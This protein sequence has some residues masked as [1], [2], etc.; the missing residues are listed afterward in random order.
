VGVVKLMESLFRYL[1]Q[2]RQV[3][4]QPVPQ[5][6][7]FVFTLS[8][9]AQVA[10]CQPTPAADPKPKTTLETT[11]SDAGRDRETELRTRAR[12]S[13]QRS[14]TKESAEELP[15][16]YL[17]QRN[18]KKK[19]SPETLDAKSPRADRGPQLDYE[20]ENDREG[21]DSRDH[22]ISPQEYEDF[23][24][25]KQSLEYRQPGD[26]GYQYP[27]D[28]R[29]PENI[30]LQHEPI[31]DKDRDN[32]VYPN[33]PYSSTTSTNNKWIDRRHHEPLD[34]AKDLRD[35]RRNA[36]LKRFGESFFKEARYQLVDANETN[37]PHDYLL[38][39]GDQINVLTYNTKG[40]ESSM[41]LTI[42]HQG[43][44]Y[45]PGA[46]R[47]ELQGL[48]ITAAQS[49]LSSALS[50]K[51][52][53]L[54]VRISMNK[55]RKIRV[56]LIGEVQ[57]PG[58]YLV[59]PGSNVLDAL[60]AGGGPTTAGSYRKIQLQRGGSSIASV[61]LYGFLATGNAPS[62]RLVYG[63]KIFVP[64]A[65]PQVAMDGEVLRPAFYELKGEST[66]A[67][68]LKLAGGVKP[69]AYAG[70][71]HIERIASGT[72]RTMDDVRLKDAAAV[73][74]QGGDSVFVNPVLEDLSLSVF[75]EGAVR[76]PGWY[77]L[78][79]N[80]TVSSLIRKAQGL[81]DD[82]Y[83]GQ[84]EVF[85][86][87]AP[88]QPTELLGVDL[89]KALGGDRK[90]DI[91]LK[92][93][94]RVIVY[95]R[96]VATFNKERVRIDGE[97]TR[98]GEYP[99][100]EAM[101]VRD[102]L[103]QAGGVTPEASPKA[104]IARPSGDG[105]LALM[106]IEVAQVLDSP[107]AKSNYKLQNGDLLVIRREL[108]AN[109]WP[110]SITLGGEV[111]NPGIYPVDLIN[112]TL[113]SVIQRAGGLTDRAYTRGTVFVRSKAE[114]IDANNEAV[115]TE[116]FTTAQQVASQIAAAEAARQGQTSSA[117]SQINL[118]SL[119][120]STRTI[121]PRDI[122]KILSNQ[123]IPLRLEKL[124]KEHVG[125]PGVKDGDLVFI[126]TMPTT[127]VVSGAVLSPTSL[128]YD[129]AWSLSDYIERAGGLAKDADP[130]EI[131]IMRASGEVVKAE[132]V[133]RLIPG[134]VVLVPPKAIIAEPG[135]FER[136]VSILQVVSNAFVFSRILR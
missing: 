108:R 82:A 20:T 52:R 47:V 42:D 75:I 103:I 86:Q 45:L 49:K 35:T 130:E 101:T 73:R 116:V 36:D 67:S 117:G 23:L 27:L 118:S 3:L 84:A 56:F 126:P 134:D 26:K 39:E 62:P 123:R 68:L 106:P 135:A 102:L 111:M 124:L 41:P 91:P 92:G 13:A 104:E 89:Q 113:E 90:Q 80:M 83:P 44:V 51:F 105:R 132:K 32:Y 2:R 9:H 107:D 112:D 98:P 25:W 133:A 87:P 8:L 125:D 15:L 74:I 109:R 119:T 57:K 31:F 11:D 66:L 12:N 30:K 100:Y 81:Q 95:D 71:I 58:A 40:G 34:R 54:R 127:L 77:A 70:L 59:N 65:G 131:L 55:V 14:R 94:D 72:Y 4:S 43:E 110:A 19:P 99:R 50:A 114:L 5:A 6:V 48:P 63:D 1:S 28:R 16:E 85:R 120:N 96:K 18:A 22:S 78:G 33:R 122:R 21:F 121:Q 128:V 64:P 61:D 60:L 115:T 76:R 29:I 136:L 69:E 10:W 7:A 37:L 38:G 46:G 79:P 97:V 93:Y 53:N 24:R 88:G 17:R 129:P